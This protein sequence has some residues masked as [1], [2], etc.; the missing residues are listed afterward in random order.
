[1]A[2][3]EEKVKA[4]AVPILLSII[5]GLLTVFGSFTLKYLSRMSDKIDTVTLQ[6]ATQQKDIDALQKGQDRIEGFYQEV[7]KGQAIK[8]D[9]Y[10]LPKRTR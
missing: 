6:Y 2:N 1:M 5:A 8:E 10:Q 4:T 9:I 3:I 7:I